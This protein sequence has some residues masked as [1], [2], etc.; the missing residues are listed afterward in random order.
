[1]KIIY[2]MAVLCSLI[3][4]GSVQATSIVCPDAPEYSFERADAVVLGYSE[5]FTRS[6]PKPPGYSINKIKVLTYWKLKNEEIPEYVLSSFQGFN[7]SGTH[8]WFLKKVP[9][10]SSNYVK[11]KSYYQ[12]LVCA[13]SISISGRR[14]DSYKDILFLST[15]E[16]SDVNQ[17]RN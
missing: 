8:I 14:L 13:P 4:A 11:G 12:K 7:S 1:M 6:A 9:P 2:S 10:E 15:K 17:S 5:S 3:F 16:A